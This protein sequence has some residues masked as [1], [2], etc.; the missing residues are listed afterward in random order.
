MLALF[1]DDKALWYAMRASGVV[2]VILLTASTAMGVFSTARAGSVRWPRFATQALHRNI[3][4]L[5]SAMLALHIVCA[6]LH[7]FVN[8]RWWDAFVPFLGP[9]EPLWIGLGSVATD[10]LIVIVLTSLVRERLQHRGWR[11]IHLASYAAW[12]IGVVH[13]FGIG[14]DSRT[15]WSLSVSAVSVGVVATFVIVRLVTLAHE[16]RLAA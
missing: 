14:T 10:L 9:Y 1:T 2:L 5:A 13:G 16:R 6:V 8:I 12:V 7:T 4:L 3:S 11:I 15:A